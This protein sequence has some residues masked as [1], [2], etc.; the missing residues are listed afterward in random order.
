M[1]TREIKGGDVLVFSNNN[2]LEAFKMA[3]RIDKEKKSLFNAMKSFLNLKVTIPKDY[4]SEGNIPK[5]LEGEISSAINKKIIDRVITVTGF[6]TAHKR[7]QAQNFNRQAVIRTWPFLGILHSGHAALSIKDD[8]DPNDKE[9]TYISRWPY[10]KKGKS[11]LNS[12]PANST[13]AE[14]LSIQSVTSSRDYKEDKYALIS[15]NTRAKLKNGEFS[16]RER[17]KILNS[18]IRLKDTI[19]SKPWGVSSDKVYL[20]LIGE[21]TSKDNDEGSFFTLFGLNEG[22]MKLY[23]QKIGNDEEDETTAPSYQMLNKKSNCSG[24]VIEA[25][26]QGGAEFYS[27][28]LNKALYYTPNFLH[29]RAMEIQGRVDDLNTKLDALNKAYKHMAQNRIYDD[30]DEMDFYEVLTELGK[31]LSSNKG[32]PKHGQVTEIYSELVR[33]RK[34]IS[35]KAPSMG[36]ITPQAIKIVDQLFK[37]RSSKDYEKGSF[38]D[39][40]LLK[41]CNNLSEI[42]EAIYK[43]ESQ[44][45]EDLIWYC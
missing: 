23:W 12:L 17:Q 20:P 43:A 44:L 13:A 26:K 37:L 15:D 18:P 28:K 35:S 7:G 27:S 33:V 3:R 29:K 39:F 2:R 24:V 34:A 41:A 14:L 40:T 11:L 42:G 8:T 10:V 31:V 38:L 19:D 16:P 21:N 32:A 45:H 1:D 25:L 4:S 5:A 9:H 22:K 6:D 30:I 36:V